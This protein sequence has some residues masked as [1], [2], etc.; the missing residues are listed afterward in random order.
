MPE[1]TTIAPQF[2]HRTLTPEGEFKAK[3][4]SEGFSLLLEGLQ[5]DCP[6]G[7]EMSLVITHLEIACT[8]AKKGMAAADGNHEP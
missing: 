6:T 2:K 1:T 3:R 5:R 4:I 7:R 8:F